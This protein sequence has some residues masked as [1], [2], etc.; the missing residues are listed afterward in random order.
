MIIYFFFAYGYFLSD[1]TQFRQLVVWLEDMKIRLYPID[2]RQNLRNLQNP[3][4]EEAFT[5][6]NESFKI[7]FI[8]DLIFQYLQDLKYPYDHEMMKDRFAVSDWLIGSAVRFEYGDNGKS[9]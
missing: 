4:W 5:K 1:E 6:V 7:L 3:Q 9:I 2:G 8:F